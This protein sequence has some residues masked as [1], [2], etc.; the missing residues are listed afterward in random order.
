[1]LKSLKT[2]N[3]T[4]APE[5]SIAKAAF[6]EPF[7]TGLEYNAPARGTWNIVHTGMLIPESHQIFICAQGCLRGVILTA[8]EMNAMDRM[9][10]V[11]I[12]ENDFLDASLEDDIVNGTTEILNK[13]ETLPP[14]VLVFLSC[15][16]L[17]ACCDFAITL[18]ELEKRFPTVDFIESYMTPTMR[19]SGLTP[20]AL[21]RKQLYSPLKPV[22]KNS[23]SI[24]IIGNDRPTDQSGRLIT[25]IKKSS[26]VIKD[27]TNCKS[28]KAFL[29]MAESAVNITYLPT[30]YAAG[31]ELERR[32]G[33]RHLHI[34]L[35]YSYHEITENFKRL[36]VE[37]DMKIP[38]FSEDIRKAEK[39][40]E[41]AHTEIGNLPITIDYTATPRPISLARLLTEHSFR[42]EKIYSEAFVATE[43]EDFI[44]LKE[45]APNILLASTVHP[46]KR[47]LK[48]EIPERKVLAI[49]QKAAYFN[50]TPYF[51]NIVSGGGLYGFSGIIRLA[52]MMIEASLKPKKT[53]ELIS[54]KGLGCESC[55]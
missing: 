40:L 9:S 30:T 37:L 42:V 14:V 3:E 29:N 8:A 55:L 52:E 24:N 47:F 54:Y 10:W 26:F 19:K 5:I 4:K 35:S 7:I 31:E 50:N 49:G 18:K 38:D 45:H 51:V 11:S 44:W 17:F 25:M 16:H 23:K 28:Y 39:A 6:P 41:A 12:C 36:S 48:K 33:Q 21:M 46:E 32:L 13:M 20:D 43:E 27:I 53:K 34:P 2:I 15:V 1:M 22:P